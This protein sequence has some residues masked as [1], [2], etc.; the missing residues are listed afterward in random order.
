LHVIW[1]PFLLQLVLPHPDPHASNHPCPPLVPAPPS[2]PSLSISIPPWTRIAD[3][4]VSRP[5][6]LPPNHRGR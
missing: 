4:Q 2:P 6:A 5:N 1:P 3:L